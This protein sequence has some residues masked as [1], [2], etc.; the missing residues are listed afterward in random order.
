[1][2]EEERM[3]PSEEKLTTRLWG[4]PLEQEEHRRGNGKTIF[5][6]GTEKTDHQTGIFLDRNHTGKT[7]LEEDARERCWAFKVLL[8]PASK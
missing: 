7:K 2:L 5:T 6:D 1:M 8:Q 3:H 4:I